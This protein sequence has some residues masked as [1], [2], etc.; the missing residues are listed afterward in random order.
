MILY[1]ALPP[2]LYEILNCAIATTSAIALVICVRYLATEYQNIKGLL[3]LK[4]A[5]GFTVFLC[6]ETA[7]MTWVWLARYIANTHHDPA[8]M[9]AIPWL[10]IPIIGSAV[11]VFGM[12]CIVKTLTPE[13]WGKW[14]YVGAIGA[15][16]FAVAVTQIV[17]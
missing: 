9:G 5:I 3:R 11:S 15:A 4:L 16:A 8:W 10:L 14:G 2:E 17:R 1:T 7:R 6:G 12:A 13:A